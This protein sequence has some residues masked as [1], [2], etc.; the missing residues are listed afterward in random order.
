MNPESVLINFVLQTADAEKVLQKFEG[1]ITKLD[2]LVTKFQKNWSKGL[3]LVKK[4][5]TKNLTQITEFHD[6][7]KKK[8]TDS[9][10]TVTDLNEAMEDTTSTF[11]K[12]GGKIGQ[13]LT[14]LKKNTNE[15]IYGWTLLSVVVGGAMKHAIT[16][17]NEFL[18]NN[19]YMR[20]NASMSDAAISGMSRE[21]MRVAALTGKSVEDVSQSVAALYD[22]TGNTEGLL[23]IVKTGA[24]MGR[25]FHANEETWNSMVAD[26]TRFSGGMVDANQLMSKFDGITGLS[27]KSLD[28][29]VNLIHEI[30]PDMQK[31]TG[32]GA[33]F[34]VNMLQVSRYTAAVGAA[35]HKMGGDLT[36]TGEVMK[37]IRDPKQW[38]QLV[39][40]MPGIAG[41][42]VQ[43]NQAYAAGDMKKYYELQQKGAART[44][45][46]TKHMSAVAIGALGI[47]VAALQ[48][49]AAVTDGVVQDNMNGVGTVA[50][51][52]KK[53]IK[54]FGTNFS[55]IWQN[56][57]N[58]ISPPFTFVVNLIA[59]GLTWLNNFMNDHLVATEI[60][61][62]TF[63]GLVSFALVRL[64]SVAKGVVGNLMKGFFKPT[65]E[66]AEELGPRIGASI[67]KTAG[68]FF[69]AIAKP[70]Q[71]A[72][73]L[74][75]GIFQVIADVIT[76][77]AKGIGNA[78][79]AI[80]GGLA[81]GLQMLGKTGPQGFMGAAMLL[82]VGAAVIFLGYGFSLMAKTPWQLVLA[83]FAGLT[84]SLAALAVMMAV[85]GPL[86]GA[87]ALVVLAFGA[88]VALVGAGMFLAA[89]AFEVIA[90]ALGLIG[91]A[92]TTMGTGL[93]DFWAAPVFRSAE[94]LIA[95]A[96]GLMAVGLT[97]IPLAAA[98]LAFKLLS[99]SFDALK[100][101]G[102]SLTSLGKGLADFW[103]APVIRAAGGLATVAASLGALG[104]A[105]IPSIAGIGVLA[106]MVTKLASIS[107]GI[108]TITTSLGG[109]NANAGELNGKLGQ[110]LIGT[111]G[112]GG[113]LDTVTNNLAN[114]NPD[115]VDK[116][117]RNLAAQMRLV[118]TMGGFDLT[119]EV[120]HHTSVKATFS[121]VPAGIPGLSDSTSNLTSDA[122]MNIAGEA[123]VTFAEFETES[124]NHHK[125]VEELLADILAAVQVS[126]TSKRE[127]TEKKGAASFNPESFAFFGGEGEAF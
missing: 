84:L 85:A 33:K 122:K 1:S 117:S 27:G 17:S 94:G 43:M 41:Y 58:A 29:V 46:M 61:V 54:D 62:V 106:I 69:D 16:A 80:L 32:G 7:F 24:M 79:E 81:R 125:K 37:S 82:A 67:A 75:R 123:E 103:E 42:L 52:F 12:S 28:D 18:K 126:S 107:T 105:A 49:M 51:N 115:Q 104:I 118:S 116:A 119:D 36:M 97:A 2:T 78:I 30:A 91:P 90:G 71:A 65:V 15:W 31:I 47:D 19:E 77:L 14:S 121:G 72:A 113:V 53:Q 50:D 3:V 40:T 13:I 109:L 92:L 102:A 5:I 38:G 98:A 68:S 8:G 112:P 57:W 11:K 34:G 100:G 10:T 21:I 45:E 89:K 83:V 64:A 96:A 108:G 95:L 120:A 25:V 74:I 86:L 44:L 70:F 76:S 6:T 99:S 60:M 111:F 9:V 59:K 48:K 124:M 73:A 87:G 35:I 101:L 127:A 4:Q 23:D 26:V 63:V 56:I 39:K 22:Q 55:A 66:M 93:A 114:F 20:T 110:S 88:A